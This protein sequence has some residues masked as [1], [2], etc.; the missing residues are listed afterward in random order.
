M[1]ILKAVE[2]RREAER[3]QW[4][5]A[6]NFLA[7]APGVVLG[8]DRGCSARCSTGSSSAGSARAPSRS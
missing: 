8:Y 3:E 4:N 6:D 7:I 1:R 5:D 2:G